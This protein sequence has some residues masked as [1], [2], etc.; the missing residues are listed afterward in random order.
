[1]TYREQAIK[2]LRKPVA[3]RFIFIV[4]VGVTVLVG[5]VAVPY[6][7]TVDGIVYISSAKSLFSDHF[8]VDYAWFREPGYPLLLRIIHFFGNSGIFIVLVQSLCLGVATFLAL[9]ATR[10]AL[11]RGRPSTAVVFFVIVLS[12]N[13]IYM[14]YSAL[15]LQQALFSLQLAF[16]ALSV[17][18]ALRL[19]VR[20]NRWAL[21]ALVLAN[22]FIA[23][24]TSIGWLYLGL[25]P[26][27]AVIAIVFSHNVV[28]LFTRVR[29]G[30]RKTAVVALSAVAVIA[31]FAGVYVSGLQ[32]YS[33][34]QDIKDPYLKTAVVPGAV[35]QPLSGPPALPPVWP[36]IQ[37]MFALMNMGTIQHYP[38]ENALFMKQQMRV[39]YAI[40]QYD[41]AYVGKPFAQYAKHWFTVPDPSNQV[42]QV[43]SWTAPNAPIVYSGT[44]IAYLLVLL[45]SLVRRRWGSFLVL[46]VPLSFLAVYALSNSPIDRYGVPAYPWAVAALAGLV[47]WIAQLVSRAVRSLRQK[48]PA[49]IEG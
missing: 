45:L 25:L 23:I 12:L 33:G 14:I 19:P 5:C 41:T 15:V 17:A 22:Y 20:L 35:I 7:A 30:L 44:F 27:V 48:R 13:P 6:K 36:L 3:Y 34:W 2:F 38:S 46:A 11:G 39:D 16:F 26:V 8:A 42:H 21:I 31:I 32:V 49:L 1:M 9:Y 18:W 47:S 40:G 4:I 43:Y 24:W 10:R 29:G 28:S 37:R